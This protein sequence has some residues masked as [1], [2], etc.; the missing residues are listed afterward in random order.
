MGSPETPQ[1]LHCK[2]LHGRSPS[3]FLSPLGTLFQ[4]LQ[5]RHLSGSHAS[6]KTNKFHCCSHNITPHSRHP[7][8][9]D[10]LDPS[11]FPMISTFL[12]LWY[13]WFA[14]KIPKFCF[15]DFI[16]SHMNDFVLSFVCINVFFSLT[17][18]SKKIQT[19][20]I[21]NRD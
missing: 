3:H 6:T 15:W 19:F 9:S 13:C 5:V 2:K 12:D 4:C 21:W 1:K 20:D 14:N 10:H 17:C 7:P 8:F 11:W 16:N 18:E